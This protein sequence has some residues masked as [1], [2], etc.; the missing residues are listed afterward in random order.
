MRH[1]EVMAS[2]WDRVPTWA[3]W[4]AAPAIAAVVLN[5]NVT[6]QG[7]PLSSV[8]L[9]AGPTTAGI[10][11][12]AKT[13]FYGG[14]WISGVLLASVGLVT[15]VAGRAK[16]LA[17]LVARTYGGVAL[18]GAAGLLLDYRDGPVRTAQLFVYLML[19]LGVLRFVRVASAAL[20]VST[21][22][23]IESNLPA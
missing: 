1:D 3:D 15:A 14:L 7:D 12:G 8:G 5:L 13:T 20:S 18:A 17:G 11:E 9:S 6:D 19:A 22:Q 4:V 10:T 23:R 21:E 2:S 16:A